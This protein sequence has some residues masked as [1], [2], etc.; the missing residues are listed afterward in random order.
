MI[1][2]TGNTSRSVKTLLWTQ[3][4]NFKDLWN[5]RHLSYTH[6]ITAGISSS[7]LPSSYSLLLLCWENSCASKDSRQ[8]LHTPPTSS[9]IPQIIKVSGLHGKHRGGIFGKRRLPWQQARQSQLPRAEVKHKRLKPLNWKF[10]SW[11]EEVSTCLSSGRKPDGGSAKNHVAKDLFYS[12]ERPFYPLVLKP[13]IENHH[14]NQKYLLL[15]P[16]L[17]FMACSS[18]N[19]QIYFLWCNLKN[20]WHLLLVLVK[21]WYQCYFNISVGCL[22]HRGR[23]P[24]ISRKVGRLVVESQV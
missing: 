20:F 8:P 15:F 5:G 6:T 2:V 9:A 4:V 19:L 22:G 16:Q 11:Q 24:C 18:L 13:P 7:P 17:S 14:P 10:D 21:C 3:C 23:V 1:R 12:F